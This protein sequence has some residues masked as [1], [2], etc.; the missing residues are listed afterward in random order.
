MNKSA[1]GAVAG[2]L[3]LFLVLPLLVMVLFLGAGDPADAGTGS[4]WGTVGGPLRADA[5]VPPDL[6]AWV[7][8][9]GTTCKD[10]TPALIAAQDEQESGWRVDAVAHNPPERGG[11]AY[12]VAQFQ[13]GT[14]ATWGA[15]AN[16]NGVNHPL[17]PADGIVAQGKLM[18]DLVEF[19]RRGLADRSLSGDLIDIALAGYNCGR[20]CVSANHGVPPAGQA[21]EYPRLIREKLPKYAASP[22]TASLARAATW[23]TAWQGGPVPYLSSSDPST[24]FGGYRRDC[25]GYVSMA[26]GL[27]G[28]GLDTGGLAARSTP[29]PASALQPGDMLINPA[30]GPAGH[31]VLFERWADA[32]H[33]SY[34]GFEQAGDGGTKHRVIPYPY[35]PGYSMTPYHLNAQ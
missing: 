18:C 22:S 25:S 12:G 24:Y 2:I 23:L 21:H 27:P 19:A 6:V 5:P 29:I 4:A 11:D 32:A 17:D 8:R 13:L 26:L 34:V 30:S 28:P 31:V 10:I 15:D 35:F 16:G 7:V 1:T 20:G 33:R 3:A 14:Y 9:A